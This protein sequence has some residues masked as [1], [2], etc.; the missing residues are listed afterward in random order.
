MDFAEYLRLLRKWFWFLLIAAF[1]GA[2][3]RYSM[4]SQI[5]PQYSANSIVAIG[6]SVNQQNS[7]ANDIYTGR[8]LAP[9]Y[10]QLLYTRDLLQGVADRLGLQ[11]DPMGLRGYFIAQLIDETSLVRIEATAGDP[12][13]VA[14]LANALAEELIARSPSD[15][16]T[17]Q[18][19]QIAL[20]TANIEDLTAQVEE[21][22][23]SIDSLDTRIQAE[24]NPTVRQQLLQERRLTIDQINVATA[25]IAQFQQ[26]ISN[27]QSRT[28]SITIVERAVF[29]TFASTTNATA[30]TITGGV[31]GAGIALGIVLVI[32][33]LDDR[34][35]TPEIAIRALSIPVLGAIPK[36]PKGSNA[37]K[38]RLITGNSKMLFSIEAEAYRRLRTNLFF[39]INRT[40]EQKPVIVVTSPGPGEGK[41]VTTAN[42]AVAIA[43]S[44]M[45]VLLIDA[46]LR[47]PRIHEI[48]QLENNIGVTT[49]LMVAESDLED[50]N[51]SIKRNFSQCLQA[52]QIPNLRVV[53]TGFTPPNP[54]ELLG[55][56]LMNYW[57][58]VFRQAN[59]VD[60]I[61]IDTPPALPFSDSMVLA[62]V[63]DAEVILVLDCQ[64]T[65]RGPAMQSIQQFAQVNVDVRGI[66]MNRLNPND[67][68]GYYGYD[69]Y[70]YTTDSQ[71][72][73]RR[74][75]DFLNRSN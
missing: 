33:Y 69:A 30:G 23:A 54:T 73:R 14:D 40:D 28:N 36:F 2:G 59:D 61:I 12:I 43:Q 13:F 38:D 65:R 9:T 22:R 15:I 29:P 4:V 72:P 11:G 63:S 32:E 37:Y 71:K 27:I 16:T 8:A 46:D 19:E 56:S 51:S 26:T 75:F 42:L 55:S 6:R 64:K 41:S 67:Q 7:N 34:L 10:V 68:A 45:R 52:T 21:Q 62:T 39:T 53:T 47:R 31:I 3:I 60:I 25:N 18:Q 24:E 20:A 1:I 49:L 50:E 66:V 5:A 58:N 57:I 48:F 74:V 44:G 70:Y 35:R 17:D